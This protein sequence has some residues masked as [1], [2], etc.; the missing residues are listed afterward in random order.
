MEETVFQCPKCSQLNTT[1]RFTCKN[2]GTNF[3]V[4][5][6]G[7][8]PM[9]KT[10]R[11]STFALIFNVFLVI[12]I[13]VI[14]SAVAIPKFVTCIGGGG[15]PISPARGIGCAISATIQE[16]H[17]DYLINAVPYTL[18][19]VLTSTSFAGGFT[20]NTTP[21]NTPAIGDIC[22]NVGG[23]KFMCNVRGDIFEWTYTPRVGDTPALIEEQAANFPTP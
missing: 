11:G 1:R 5:L 6:A 15:P 14:L 2:C 20:Y 3:E 13:L 23:N 21:N 8:E 16:K 7:I 9:E 22:S 12:V 4:A 17:S 10:T 19:D 18:D